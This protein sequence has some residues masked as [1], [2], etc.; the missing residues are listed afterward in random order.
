MFGHH[1][2]LSIVSNAPHYNPPLFPSLQ[3]YDYD[4]CPFVLKRP[5]CDI[6]AIHAS[7]IYDICAY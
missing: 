1:V 7:A 6:V 4:S 3:K 2:H 5:A